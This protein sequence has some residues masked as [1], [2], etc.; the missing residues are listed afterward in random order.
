M[1]HMAEFGFTAGGV[2]N[3]LATTA[4]HGGARQGQV[5]AF[6]GRNQGN[7]VCRRRVDGIGVACHWLRFPCKDRQIQS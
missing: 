5:G 1:G 4:G 7:F 2:N 3:R 6:P